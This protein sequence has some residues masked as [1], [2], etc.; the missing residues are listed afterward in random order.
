MSSLVG[1]EGRSTVH[2]FQRSRCPW[3][4]PLDPGLVLGSTRGRNSQ[5][6]CVRVQLHCWFGDVPSDTEPSAHIW[7]STLPGEHHSL[8][9]LK[10]VFAFFVV[11]VPYIFLPSSSLYLYLV[12]VKY[13]PGLIFPDSNP[14]LMIFIPKICCIK[15]R[16]QD[17]WRAGCWFCSAACL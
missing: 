6:F 10:K 15:C 8:Y 4:E 2:S 5:S 16:S 7:C 9:T 17:W 14:Q 12:L 11:A 1:K 13:I 3:A